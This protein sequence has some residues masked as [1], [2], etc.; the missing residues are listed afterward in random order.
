[1]ANTYWHKQTPAEP[2]FPDLLWSR[3]E[4]RSSAGK[5]LIVGGNLHGF[6]APAMAFNEAEAAGI[7]S[8]R[9][10]LPDA[11][12]KL[13]GGFLTDGEFAPS[14]PSGSFSQKALDDL[15]EQ[16]NWSD[17]TLFA[18]DLGRNSET[19][20]VIEKFLEKSPTLVTLTKDAADYA[21]A[22]PK[23]ILDRPNT[24]VVL[25]MSQLQKLALLMNP[26]VAITFGMDLV[27]LVEALHTITSNYELKIIVKHLNQMICAV[28]GNVST[29]ALG[30]DLESW[31]IKTATHTSVWWVQNPTKPFEAITTSF[32]T[33][34]F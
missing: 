34:N 29:T 27:R 6:S 10:L 7:G 17:A 25:T 28:D 11:V 9:V 22:L 23:L 14:T 21:I 12:K 20:I 32:T 4:R 1:M 24:L 19:A 31:R 8:A 30:T 26:A 5:L 15:L 2:L 3:P 13:V 16:A 33:I 18:G